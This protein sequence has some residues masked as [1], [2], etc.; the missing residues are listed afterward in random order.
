MAQSHI[1]PFLFIHSFI[2]FFFVS[3]S[4]A[5][6]VMRPPVTD[7]KVDLAHL[8]DPFPL[9]RIQEMGILLSRA[10]GIC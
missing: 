9:K 7:R 4:V 5:F 6:D 8:T 2:Q 3:L 10:A 1:H